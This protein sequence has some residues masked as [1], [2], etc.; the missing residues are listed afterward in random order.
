MLEPS[1]SHRIEQ[2]VAC[3]SV[4]ELYRLEHA[5]IQNLYM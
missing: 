5:N 3:Q 1:F 2:V 4:L